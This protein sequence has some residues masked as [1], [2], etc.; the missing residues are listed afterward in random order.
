M[1]IDTELAGKY[2]EFFSFMSQ[3]HG[4]TLT[5]SEMDEIVRESQKLVEKSTPMRRVQKI[6]I[7]KKLMWKNFSMNFGN[8]Y[9]IGLCSLYKEMDTDGEGLYQ[10]IPEL[11]PPFKNAFD[12]YY[13]WW[14]HK[15]YFR[16]W[17]ERHKAI[18]RA[19]KK[20]RKS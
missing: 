8:K 9:T 17:W 3:E 1:Y 2:Q 5:V 6:E 19:I 15:G 4:L 16:P 7:L 18:R 14:E 12:L 10:D 20:L 11:A 13:F